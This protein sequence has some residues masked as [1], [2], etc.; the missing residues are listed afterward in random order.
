M[1]SLEDPRS[2]R[3]VASIAQQSTP[4][5]SGSARPIHYYGKQGELT[6]I[7]PLKPGGA[8]QLREFLSRTRDTHTG[9]SQAIAIG[10]LHDMRVAILDND[11]R[12]LFATTYDG[13]WDQYIDDFVSNPATFAALEGLFGTCEGFP[14]MQSPDVKDYLVKY[15]LNV[16]YFWTAYPDATA[17]RIEKGLRVLNA[18]EEMLDAAG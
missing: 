5:T 15:Q 10:T 14:G 6:M 12:M 4:E 8:E 3:R 7:A 17:N 13:D 2:D 9:E 18:W 11:S 1:M 16:E